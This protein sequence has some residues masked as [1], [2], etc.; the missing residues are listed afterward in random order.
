MLYK[1][2][3]DISPL[4][5]KL[6]NLSGGLSILDFD[7]Y[8]WSG[9]NGSSIHH[10]VQTAFFLLNDFPSKCFTKSVLINQFLSPTHEYF[11]REKSR[12]HFFYFL[13]TQMENI[14]IVVVIIQT[15]IFMIFLFQFAAVME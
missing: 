5:Y 6:Y 7:T 15:S 3:I 10:V 2:G 1:P 12:D 4:W 9:D 11:S 14:S 13:E 8:S